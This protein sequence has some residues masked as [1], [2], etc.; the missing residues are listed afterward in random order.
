MA[1]TRI[2]E[3][4]E[5]ISAM[6]FATAPGRCSQVSRTTTVSGGASWA[7][8][9]PAVCGCGRSDT[10]RS[11]TAPRPRATA[12]AASVSS[13]CRAADRSTKTFVGCCAA[14]YSVTSRVLPIPPG[15]VTV[16]TADA[17]RAAVSSSSAA[18]PVT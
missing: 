3:R 8:A 5:R 1:I 10:L 12:T 15:P 6:M 11:G 14:M 2:S 4:R 18:V 16:T 17:A 7:T 13:A 9:A